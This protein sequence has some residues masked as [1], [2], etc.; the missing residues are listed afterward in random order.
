[1]TI[2]PYQPVPGQMRAPVPLPGLPPQAQSQFA[3]APRLPAGRQIPM[4]AQPQRQ[5]PQS[6][7]QIPDSG[8]MAAL[9]RAQQIM[10]ASPNLPAYYTPGMIRPPGAGPRTAEQA[11]A[12]AQQ[13]ARMQQLYAQQNPQMGFQ[14][15]APRFYPVR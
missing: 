3:S 9:A 13:N 5:P 7:Y 15:Q 10:S 14:P 12:M 4:P 2:Q 6:P 1:M 8:L 11:N